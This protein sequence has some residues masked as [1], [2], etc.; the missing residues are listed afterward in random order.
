MTPGPLF[1]SVFLATTVEAVEATTIVLAAG[2][3]RDWRSAMRGTVA[4]LVALAVMVAALSP[5]L[6]AIPLR[7]IRL[8]I[9]A[10]LLWFGLKWLRKG[11]QRAAGTRAL[12]DEAAAYQRELASA[13]EAG[14]QRWWLDTDRYA[15]VLSFQ[16]VFLEGLEIVFI[17]LTLGSNAHRTGLAA[18]AAG[19]AVGVVAL[20]GLAVRAPLARVPENTMKLLVGVMLTSFGL[21]WFVEGTGAQWPGDDA[22]LAVIAPGIAVLTIASIGALRYRRA[23]S[24]IDVAPLESSNP[25]I[26]PS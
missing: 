21:L 12:H 6:S 24:A 2:I 3:A 20:A 7:A 17:V 14:E 4:A 10:A 25:R 23:R 9:G 13:R 19:A 1:V 26:S 15:F 16:G 8:V 5:V 11:V 18:V 22:A